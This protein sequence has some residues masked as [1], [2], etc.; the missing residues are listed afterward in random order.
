MNNSQF[1]YVPLAESQWKQNPKQHEHLNHKHHQKPRPATIDDIFP[2]L[3]R[4]AI[5]YNDVFSNLQTL[6]KTAKQATYPPYNLSKFGD[7]KF[8]IRIAIA[9]FKKDE[10][11][12]T[13]VDRTLTIE[14]DT[15]LKLGEEAEALAGEILHQGIAQRDFKLNFALAEFVEVVSVEM[16]DGILTIKLETQIPEEKKPKVF[17]IK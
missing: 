12:V 1:T 9:G 4:W 13:A 8:E 2:K 15:N 6:S 7:D 3:D 16:A 11:K 14:S 5:G 10:V 17:D